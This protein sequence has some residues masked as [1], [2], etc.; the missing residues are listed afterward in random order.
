MKKYQDQWRR[1]IG[2]AIA[3]YAAETGV[4]AVDT[5][6]LVVETPPDPKMGD[7]AFPMFPYAKVLRKGPPVIAAEVARRVAAMSGA[8]G[9]G[10]AAAAGPYVNVRL[11]PAAVIADILS[12]ITAQGTAFGRSAAMAGTR[13][14][15]EFSCPNTNKPLHLGHLQKRRHRREPLAHPAPR[16]VPPC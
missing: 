1:V 14:M 2:E 7:I 8:A 12:E 13:V 15:L 5:S 6:A 4:T 11:E 9:A 3:S 10:T 16:P